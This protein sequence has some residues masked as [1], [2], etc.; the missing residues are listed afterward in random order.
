MLTR[1]KAINLTRDS[2]SLVYFE[3]EDISQLIHMHCQLGMSEM[4]IFI[5]KK[6]VKKITNT[7]NKKGFYNR[8]IEFE[9]LEHEVRL[10]VSWISNIG[11]IK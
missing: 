2:E 11:D 8:I 7:L 3:L 6:S 9:A 4:E 10:Y 1:Q 5:D